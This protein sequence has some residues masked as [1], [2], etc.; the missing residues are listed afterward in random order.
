MLGMAMGMAVSSPTP[1]TVRIE[2]RSGPLSSRV[3]NVHLEFTRPVSD[4]TFTYSPCAS[5]HREEAHY[6]LSVVTSSGSNRLV[7]IIPEDAPSG[8]CIAA[9]DAQGNVVGRSA[10]QLIEHETIYRRNLLKRSGGAEHT[11]PRKVVKRG[12]EMHSITMTNETGI[13]PL[14]PWFDGVALLEA[15]GLSII[16]ADAAKTSSIAIVGAGMSGLMSYL[17]LTQAG[18]SNVSIIEAGDRLGGR[19]HTTYLSGGPFDYSYNEMGPMRFP[20]SGTVGNE[21]YNV[22][23]HQ[24]VFQLAAELNEI[25]GGAANWSVNFIPWIQTNENGLV[26]KNGIKTE[27]GLPP[28]RAQIAENASLSVP[29]GEID[30]ATLHIEKLLEAAKPGRE[31]YLEMAQNMFKAHKYWLENGLGG[32]PG[33]QWSE[34]AYMVNY[35]KASLNSTDYIGASAH[36]F[37]EELYGGMYFL[38]TEWLTID[39][40]LNRLPLA[41]HPTVDK[42]TTMGR[43]IQKVIYQSAKEAEDKPKVELQWREKNSTAWSSAEYDYAMLSVPFSIMKR[44]RFTPSLPTTIGSAVANVPYKAACKVALEYSERFWEHYESP[45]FGGCSTTS[46]IPGIGTICYPSYNMNSTGPATILASYIASPDWG[47]R[48]LS[49]SEEEHVSYVLDAMTEIHGEETRALYTG[50]YDRLCWALDELESASWAAPTVGQH[51]LYLPE[52]FK[53]HNNMIFIGEHTSYTHAW[54]ASALESG[55]RG[56]V[57]LMLELGLVDEAKATVDKWMARWIDV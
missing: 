6:I 2:T 47:I 56:S 24:L 29:E 7:W 26:Y 5:S 14:G 18:F 10:P 53:T 22:T 16:D 39:G 54:I 46:D 57:Q 21:T 40:G 13:D 25:N 32:L 50:K 49:M 43:K 30:E 42:D 1:H 17:L 52:Y 44:W 31:F 41:F 12:D 28:T 38:A 33:D 55:I 4:L 23:D 3:A 27:A 20:L 15:K 19:V 45:I 51:E 11:V 9:F 36:T 35:L 8:G 37:W 48:L 34:F